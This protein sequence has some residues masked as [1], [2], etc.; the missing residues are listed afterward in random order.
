MA[1]NEQKYKNKQRKYYHGTPFDKLDKS[2]D[3]FGCLFLTTYFPY[4]VEYSKIDEKGTF[5]HVFEFKIKEP[6]NIF[7][8]QSSMDNFKLHKNVSP[9]LYA[10]AKT[11][12][13]LTDKRRGHL[14][15]ELLA[16]IKSLGYDGFFDREVKDYEMYDNP[17]VGVFYPEKLLNVNT[18]NY[19]DFF[20]N[21][22]FVNRHDIDIRKVEDAFISEYSAGIKDK[23]LISEIIFIDCTTTLPLEEIDEIIKD[24]DISK[25][26]ERLP[27]VYFNQIGE[28]YYKFGKR[29]SFIFKAERFLKL[30]E[31]GYFGGIE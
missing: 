20:L 27:P 30:K 31:M 2:L 6:L 14:R 8:I 24:I 21:K 4:A 15:G 18:Y 22:D 10:L 9:D 28:P 26:E 17:T 23:K 5:G 25:L 1:F 7:N 19:Q 13:W 16:K 29:K 3:R 11:N 12:N